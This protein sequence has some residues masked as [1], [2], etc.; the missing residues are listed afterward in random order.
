M[1]TDLVTVLA[2]FAVLANGDIDLQSFYL[3]AGKNGVGGLNRHSTI[4][5]DVSITPEDYFPFFRIVY[6][7]TF[8][9]YPRFLSNEWYLRCGWCREHEVDSQHHRCQLSE[10][11]WR[12]QFCV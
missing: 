11:H 8:A 10:G 9:F 7:D 1:D 2:N 12:V 4:E 6:L 5:A 3:G